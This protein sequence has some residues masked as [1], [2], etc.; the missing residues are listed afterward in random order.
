MLWN[1]TERSMKEN[2]TKNELS[3]VGGSIFFLFNLMAGRCLHFM[4]F[5]TQLR[6]SSCY[7]KHCTF[8]LTIKY[9]IFILF[10]E[11]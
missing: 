3:D 11:N 4:V 8:S 5:M 1:W 10:Y 9:F 7:F 2:E 6:D